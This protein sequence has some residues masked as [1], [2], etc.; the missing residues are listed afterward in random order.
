MSNSK[1]LL[2]TM[3]FNIAALVFII[4]VSFTIAN[5][6]INNL[7]KKDLETIGSSIYS[8]SS[9]FIKN[10]SKAYENKEFKDAINSIKIGKSGYVYFIDETGKIVIHPSIEGQNLANLDFIQK[11]LSDKNSGI[12]EYYTD[13]TNQ[14]KIIFYKYIPEW[15]VW[16]V[17]G[18]NKDDYVKDIYFEFFY[19][20]VI[21][22]IILIIIQIFVFFITS[23]GITKNINNFILYFKEFLNFVTYKQNKIEKRDIKGNCEFSKMSKQINDVIDE[24]DGKYKDDMRVI[25]ES[26]LTF[27]KLKKGVFRCR[28]KS[29]TSN[30]MIN[31]L[32]NTI[33][34][35]LDDLEKYMKDI[36]N[37][38][39]SYTNNNYKSRIDIS[40]ELIDESRLLKVM[41]S[42]NILGDTLSSQSKQN[43]DNGNILD[44][45]SKVLKSSIEKLTTKLLEQTNSLEFTTQAVDKISNITKNNTQNALQMSSLGE[46]VK[47]SVEDGYNL[48]NQTNLSMDEI[49]SKVLAI[50]EAISIID[51]ISFQTNILSLNAA[52]EAATAGEAGKGF[53]V[54]AQEVRSLANK[55]SEA[56]NDIK[57]LVD[58]ANLKAN[59]GKE[60]SNKMKEGYKNLF[61]NITQTLEI[62]QNVSS[63]ANEQMRGIEEVNQAIITLEKISKENEEETIQVNNITKEVSEMAFEVLEEAKNK[64]F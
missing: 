19:K 44:N 53:A 21:L 14:D 57:N 1:K 45:N 54:V 5:K 61:S 39:M 10:G 12:I 22:G 9:I 43:L 46:I 30:P 58:I 28:I 24:F 50:N 20:I 35:A 16:L 60:I 56:A 4:T 26:I 62:I 52:V 36:E 59:E 64:I 7:I 27:D 41:K 42:V 34:E 25:G 38:L 8:L 49:N 33:N 32:K 3:F 37:I 48:T 55:S 29:T 17:P 6:N 23:R 2:L 18:I 63:A 15:K 13:V 47:K 11:I 51:Q 40:K 31:T